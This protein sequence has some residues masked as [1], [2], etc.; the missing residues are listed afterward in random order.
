[1]VGAMK[2][3]E[4]TDLKQINT[5]VA[6]A[7]GWVKK[8]SIKPLGNHDYY[9]H[10]SKPYIVVYSGPYHPSSGNAQTWELIERLE[11]SVTKTPDGWEGDI[12]GRSLWQQGATPAIAICKAVIAAKWGDEIPD[13]IMARVE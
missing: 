9:I 1:M 5:L 6:L 4:L 8:I 3:S 2:V 13:E 11:V 7:Q 10:P 12:V